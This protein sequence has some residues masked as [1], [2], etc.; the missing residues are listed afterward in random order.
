HYVVVGDKEIEV[1]LEAKT[2]KA[3]VLLRGA[4]NDIAAHAQSVAQDLAPRGNT[5]RLRRAIKV[6]RAIA[7]D[8]NYSAEV[9]LD[10]DEA[11]YALFVMGGT[12]M[13]ARGGGGRFLGGRGR[14]T[15]ADYGHRGFPIA[16]GIVR[17]SFRGQRAQGN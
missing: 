5:G 1:A 15:A 16:H 7:S 13:Y 9:Y 4:V 11:P 2:R 17:A 14:I 12:G 6:N 8:P 10:L 3:K